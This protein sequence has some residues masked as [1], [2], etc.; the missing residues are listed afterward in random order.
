[1]TSQGQY[2][3]ELGS[4]KPIQDHGI[5]KNPSMPEELKK[6][7]EKNTKAKKNFMDFPPSTKKIHLDGF[8]VENVRK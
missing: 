7:L 1:M 8:C 4:K 3:Y 2:F 5:P 6:A